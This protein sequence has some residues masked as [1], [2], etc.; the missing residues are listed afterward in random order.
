MIPSIEYQND[1]YSHH[2]E[3]FVDYFNE[4][5]EQ[6]KLLGFFNNS[7]V[8]DFIKIIVDN[9]NFKDNFDDEE[10]FSDFSDEEYIE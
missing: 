7:K 3:Y 2:L 4:I 8:E 1:F 6:Y 5:K 10:E 9:L